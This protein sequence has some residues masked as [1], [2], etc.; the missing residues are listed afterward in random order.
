MSTNSKKDIELIKY[1]NEILYEIQNNNNYRSIN[2]LFMEPET[3]NTIVFFAKLINAKQILELGSAIGFSSIWLATSLP[4]TNITSLEHNLK[5]FNS[6]QNY[7]KKTKIENLNL[8]NTDI[9]EHTKS[10]KDS[11]FD[12]VIQDSKKAL[13][14]NHL[15]E[16][17]RLTRTGGLIIADD[18]MLATKGYP[19]KITKH[20]N[21]YNN[22]VFN[23]PNLESIMLSCGDGILISKVFK[24]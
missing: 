21:E 11:S 1:P 16:T 12:I 19:D 23:H 15:E 17:I 2:R 13:Y 9:T 7:L 5:Y 22:L 6:A 24:K 20:I 18:T 8:I 4:E 14:P 3:L 10:L